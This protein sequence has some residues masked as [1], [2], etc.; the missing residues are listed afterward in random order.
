MSLVNNYLQYVNKGIIKKTRK[1]KGT[2]ANRK[3]IE[4]K[5]QTVFSKAIDSFVLLAKKW[6]VNRL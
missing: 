3:K 5:I 4:I 6:F 1:P 2:S